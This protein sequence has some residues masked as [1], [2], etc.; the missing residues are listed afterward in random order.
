MNRLCPAEKMLDDFDNLVMIYF[1]FPIRTRVFSVA[2][3]TLWI[4]FYVSFRSAATIITLR[5]HLKT[6][7]FK[8][9]PM[10]LL[11]ISSASFCYFSAIEVNV[12][13]NGNIA[14]YNSRAILWRRAPCCCSSSSIF[15]RGKFGSGS[16]IKASK[17]TNGST[18]FASEGIDPP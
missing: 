15:L 3:S 5:R 10:L 16:S 14:L 7:L 2:A 11:I 12:L 8:S 17:T 6:S 18:Q 9:L 1:L 13:Y 4:P